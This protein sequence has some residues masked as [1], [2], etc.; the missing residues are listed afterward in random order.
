MNR[1]CI[2]PAMLVGLYSV[3]WGL[4]TP[5]PF[6]GAI[7]HGLTG[8]TTIMAFPDGSGPP[9]T[10][11]RQVDTNGDLE[12][13]LSDIVLFSQDLAAQ[14]DIHPRSDFNNDGL[15]NLT[16]VTLFSQAIGLV[17]E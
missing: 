1:I 9:L 2:I 8:P 15:I 5:I 16:D 11:A 7:E 6:A 14:S 4:D 12:I 13:N 3:A 17:C 10:E